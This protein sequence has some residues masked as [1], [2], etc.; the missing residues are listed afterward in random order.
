MLIKKGCNTCISSPHRG[1]EGHSIFERQVTGY[2]RL[3]PGISFHM[4]ISTAPCGDSRIFSPADEKNKSDIHPQRSVEQ[5][6]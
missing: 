6:F 1:Q 4:Y 3:R 2:Y 5:M